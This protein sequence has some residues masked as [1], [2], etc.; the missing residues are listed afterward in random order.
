MREGL[1]VVQDRK[2]GAKGRRGVCDVAIQHGQV[3]IINCHVRHEKRVKQ[4]VGQLGMEYVLAVERGEVILVGDFNTI[5]EETARRRR[6]T[7]K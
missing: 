5:P 2:V 6:W 4:Y 7:E 3:V 1:S